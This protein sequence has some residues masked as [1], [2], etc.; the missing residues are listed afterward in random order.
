MYVSSGFFPDKIKEIPLFQAIRRFASSKS[1]TA[2][3]LTSL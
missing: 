2:L 3:S 1:Q